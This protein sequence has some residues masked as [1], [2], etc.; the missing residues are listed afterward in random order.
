MTYEKAPGSWSYGIEIFTG[1]NI[2]RYE[3]F[4]YEDLCNGQQVQFTGTG[5]KKSLEDQIEKNYNGFVHI[6]QRK[7]MEYFMSRRK[8]NDIRRIRT[9]VHRNL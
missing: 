5:K 4:V 6:K 3:I 7:I 8:N 9:G 1:R 2:Y